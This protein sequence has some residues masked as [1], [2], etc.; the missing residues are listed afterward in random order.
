VSFWANGITY[1]SNTF[2]WDYNMGFLGFRYYK[3]TPGNGDH[4]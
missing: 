2:F 3:T 4:I 1:P